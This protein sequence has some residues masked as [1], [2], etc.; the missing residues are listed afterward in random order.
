M[1][2]ATETVHFLANHNSDAPALEGSLGDVTQ[3]RVIYLT[4]RIMAHHAKDLL[5]L[6]M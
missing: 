3:C 5:G 1:A 2:K 4:G 6:E